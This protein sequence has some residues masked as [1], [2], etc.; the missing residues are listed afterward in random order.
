MP[1]NPQ[2]DKLVY[3]SLTSLLF[4][5]IALFHLYIPAKSSSIT[6]IKGTV[7]RDFALYMLSHKFPPPDSPRKFFSNLL[8]ILENPEGG[9]G[10]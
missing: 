7:A 9:G 4:H 6:T 2:L 10:A 3:P 1:V 8:S 5:P